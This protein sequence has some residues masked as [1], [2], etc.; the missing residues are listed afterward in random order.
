MN[1]LKTIKYVLLAAVAIASLSACNK[2]DEVSVEEVYA[3]WKKVNDEWLAEQVKRTDSEGKPYYTQLVPR[4]NPEVFV[5]IRYLSD[6]K[7]TEG[8]L[9]PLYT[10]TIDTRYRLESY[11]GTP[12]DSSTNIMTYGKGIFR[13]QLT[14]VVEGWAIACMDMRVG[15]SAEVIVPYQVGYGTSTTTSIAPYTNL[16]FNIR[17]VDIV[18]YEVNPE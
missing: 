6:R 15:D 14:N 12:M 5:L 4:W 2:K 18:D 16:K 8:H 17:L 3:E 11:D 9:S 1:M 7:A 10:S 13:S